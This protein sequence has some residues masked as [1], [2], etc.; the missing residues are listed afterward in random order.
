MSYH[1]K[2]NEPLNKND[3]NKMDSDCSFNNSNFISKPI[4]S[5]RCTINENTIQ[6]QYPFK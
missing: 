4:K 2:F 1:N 3:S 5:K 6:L